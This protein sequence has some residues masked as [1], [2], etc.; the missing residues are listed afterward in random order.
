[1]GKIYKGLVFDDE[2]SVS[3]LDTTDIVNEAI[4]LHG[5]SPLSAA[6]LGRALTATAYMATSLK[7]ENFRLSVTI[8]GDGAGGRII[9]AAD[10]KLNVRGNIDN[11]VADLPLKEN[12]KLDVAGLVGKGMM[13]VVKSMGLKEPYVGKCRLVSGEIAED[14]TA[15]YAYSEQQPTAMALGVYIGTDGSCLGAGGVVFQP[16]PDAKEENVEKAEEVIKGFSDISKQIYEK[17]ANKIIE[18][19]FNGVKFD[20]YEPKYKCNCSK[21]YIDKVLISVGKDELLKTVNEQG[22]VEVLCEFCDKKYCYRRA[23]IDEL[24]KG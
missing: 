16:L 9:T 22:E 3:V 11:R 5:L 21:E 20:L 4:R 2:I 19:N 15:Y 12:G 24:F 13:T 23:D 7:D 18:D 17:G 6:G 1:M 8:S 14:F 10:G